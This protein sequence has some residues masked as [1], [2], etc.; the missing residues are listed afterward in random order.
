LCVFL[1]ENYTSE[2]RDYFGTQGGD[3]LCIGLIVL[4]QLQGRESNDH[5][6]ILCFRL[7][8]VDNE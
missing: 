2:L 8:G 4:K 7:E 5:T 1:D 6:L 3:E